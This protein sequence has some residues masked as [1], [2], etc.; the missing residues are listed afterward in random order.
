MELDKS[1]TVAFTGHRSFKM[2]GQSQEALY[3]ATFNNVLSLCDQGYDT[4]LTGMAEGFD[5]LAALTVLTI[6]IE[7]KHI[8][9]I[10]VVPFVG[11]EN[12]F[13]IDDKAVYET[14]LDKVSQKVIISDHYQ[15]GVYHRRNDFLI[16]NSSVLIACYN[17]SPRGTKYTFE[18]ARRQGHKIINLL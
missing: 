18:R 9:L 15:V 1:K 14:I 6:Q 12:G 10:A 11:Q 4:F 2:K 16:D 17:G 3:Q 13:L 7:Y 5:M 8:S